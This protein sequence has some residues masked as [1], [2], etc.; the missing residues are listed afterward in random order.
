MNNVNTLIEE[1]R[2]LITAT[3]ISAEERFQ[4][5]M[6]RAAGF[7]PASSASRRPKWRSVEARGFPGLH[8]ARVPGRGQGTAGEGE[9]AHCGQYLSQRHAV[10]R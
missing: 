6:K 2:T 7:W 8:L 4:A 3:E 1:L 5:A 10:P 9:A